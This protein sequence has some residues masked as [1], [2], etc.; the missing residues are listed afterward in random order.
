VHRWLTGVYVV[1]A[2]VAVVVAWFPSFMC[3]AGS[4]VLFVGLMRMIWQNRKNPPRQS[5]LYYV[6][7]LVGT[8][9]IWMGLPLPVDVMTKAWADCL[10]LAATVALLGGLYAYNALSP[11]AALGNNPHS[12]EG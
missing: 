6:P 5:P 8:N 11:R 9:L 12:E 2:L 3:R 7:F 10:F 1:G 4:A